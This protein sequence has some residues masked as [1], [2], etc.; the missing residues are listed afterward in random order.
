MVGIIK[1]KAASK[2]INKYFWQKGNY[3]AHVKVCCQNSDSAPSMFVIWIFMFTLFITVLWPVYSCL[4]IKNQRNDTN[5]MFCNSSCTFID[6]HCIC[7]GIFSNLHSLN[8]NG[9][10]WCDDITTQASLILLWRHVNNPT[11]MY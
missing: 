9:I 2:W 5:Y 8:F 7:C 4:L 1:P 6:N 10:L 3:V 11:Q